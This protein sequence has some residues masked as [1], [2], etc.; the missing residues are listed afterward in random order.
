MTAIPFARCGA[1]LE[2]L[3]CLQVPQENQRSSQ[4]NKNKKKKKRKRKKGGLETEKEPH[5]TETLTFTQP[6]KMGREVSRA[7]RGIG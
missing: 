7:T 5:R 2:D 4:K 6:L 1:G 3:L